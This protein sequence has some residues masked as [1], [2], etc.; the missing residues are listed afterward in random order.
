M[1]VFLV[2][3]LFELSGAKSFKGGMGGNFQNIFCRIDNT[4]IMLAC[5][6]V[7]LTDPSRKLGRRNGE[8]KPELSMTH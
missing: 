1:H 6:T 4:L 7:R 2:Y 8:S 3:M 5:D